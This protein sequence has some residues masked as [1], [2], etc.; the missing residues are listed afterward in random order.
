MILLLFCK[1]LCRLLL[2]PFIVLYPFFLFVS[3]KPLFV[4]KFKLIHF[5]VKIKDWILNAAASRWKT[6]T[7]A[8][9][10][11]KN[12]KNMHIN[13]YKGIISEFWPPLAANNT[14]HKRESKNKKKFKLGTCNSMTHAIKCNHLIIIVERS[15]WKL[16]LGI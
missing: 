11:T 8:K 5:C 9:N 10:K 15:K 13:F 6:I 3:L 4:W 2:Y 16:I 1:W 12:K 14:N 7:F